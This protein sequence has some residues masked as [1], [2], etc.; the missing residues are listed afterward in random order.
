MNDL[1]TKTFTKDALSELEEDLGICAIC[2]NFDGASLTEK[3]GAQMISVQLP[4]EEGNCTKESPSGE[5]YLL[6]EKKGGCAGKELY[7]P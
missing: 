2:K 3:D 6:L 5:P 7:T 1:I 4:I